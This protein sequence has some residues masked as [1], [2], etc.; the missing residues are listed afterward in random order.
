MKIWHNK[1]L[2]NKIL[3]ILF[4]LNFDTIFI[5]DRNHDNEESS[6][7]VVNNNGKNIKIEKRR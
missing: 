2:E 1:S 4:S 6:T 3:K 5:N 7:V